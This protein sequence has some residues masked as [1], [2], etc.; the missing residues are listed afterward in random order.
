MLLEWLT[1]TGYV[2]ICCEAMGGKGPA[3]G[4]SRV[5]RGAQ[6][7][8]MKSDRT[9]A[10]GPR[11]MLRLCAAVRPR[12]STNRA[13]KMGLNVHTN[14]LWI[15]VPPEG[16]YDWKAEQGYTGPERTTATR[17]LSASGLHLLR[18]PGLRSL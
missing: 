2:N 1:A 14:Y 5:P 3:D 7:E 8:A 9:P 11:G 18:R 12:P 17:P 13:A 6:N 4:G 16:L 10:A 15:H